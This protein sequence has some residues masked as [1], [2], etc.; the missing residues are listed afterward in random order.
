MENKI[1]IQGFIKVDEDDEN[2]NLYKKYIHTNSDF[3]KY[4]GYIGE[5]TSII[6]NKIGECEPSKHHPTEEDS[7][8][9]YYG[10]VSVYLDKARVSFYISDKEINLEEVQDKFTMQLLGA[11]DIYGE[12][13]GYSEFTILGFDLE[14]FTIGNHNLFEILS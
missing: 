5:L 4:S 9:E 2:I 14:N 10:G 1:V 6:E 7:D 12:N 8:F 3:M 13:Y 11:L